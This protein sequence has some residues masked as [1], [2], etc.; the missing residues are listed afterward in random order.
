MRAIY[1]CNSRENID[2]VYGARQREMLAALTDIDDSVY[3][4]DEARESSVVRRAEVIFSTWGMPRLEKAEIREIFPELRAVFYAAGSVQAFAG[5]FISSG[6]KV[7]SAW[8]ANGVPVA[9]YSVAQI[10]LAAKGYFRLMQLM[11]KNRADAREEMQNYPGMFDIKVGLLG[12]GAIGSYV[13]EMLKGYECRVLAYDPFASDE[14]MARL[15]AERATMEEIFADCDIVSNHLANLPETQKIIRREHLL[16]MKDYS[17]FINTGR[18]MQLDEG[19]LL[20]LLRTKPTVTAL[21][22]VLIDEENSDVNPLNALPNCFITP[23][24]AGSMGNE[25]RRMAEYMAEECGRWQRGE[26]LRY[27]VTGEMLR[28][29]A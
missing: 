9:E 27:E 25:V 16:S 13:A 15:G 19:D 24:I 18:G 8:M 6:V 1:L 7:F 10:M 2:R 23:H 17:T 21:L 3:T 12:L 28:T 22:D 20:E 29:M 11:R 14:K 4:L 26:E 5:P